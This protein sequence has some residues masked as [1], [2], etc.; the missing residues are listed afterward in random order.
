F[1]LPIG[2]PEDAPALVNQA[3]LSQEIVLVLVDGD[4]VRKVPLQPIDLERNLLLRRSQGVIDK[5]ASPVDVFDR[6]LVS[7]KECLL[8]AEHLAEQGGEVIFG[9]GP[10]RLALVR[11]CWHVDNLGDQSSPAAYRTA[12]PSTSMAGRTMPPNAIPR[13]KTAI[14]R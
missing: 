6:I 2:P 12:T 8:Q 13:H 3:V 11:I 5:T 9:W 7:Q 10:R 4:G 14:R 1:N